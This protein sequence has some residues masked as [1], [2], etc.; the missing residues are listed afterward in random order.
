LKV[1]P[2]GSIDFVL[3]TTGEA[4]KFLHLMQP[5]TS[6]IVSISTTPSGKQLQESSV[7]SRPDKPQLPW[8][9]YLALNLMDSINRLRAWR[10]GVD[11][12][13]MFLV[14]NGKD[15]TRLATYVEEV[16]LMPVVGSRAALND[17]DSV[18]RIAGLVHSGKGGLGKAVIEVRQD[19]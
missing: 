11:Y 8:I 12:Q 19:G 14:P 2:R 9:P 16:S 18:K 4:L 15:L 1:I 3:D 10:W 7:M 13:Y 5:S 17:I 6:T